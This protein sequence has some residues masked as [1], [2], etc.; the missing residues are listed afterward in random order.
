MKKKNVLVSLG[1][2]VA[3]MSSVLAGCAGSGSAA[4]TTTSATSV[5]S[6]TEGSAQAVQVAPVTE[7]DAKAEITGN[8]VFYTADPEE[9]A[10][11][12]CE[13]FIA[14]Y[15][16]CTYTLYRSGTGNLTTKLSAETE[17]GGTEC[18][19]F[20]FSNLSYIYGLEED[21]MLYHWT[22]DG[23]ENLIDTT[24]GDMAYNYKLEV[25]GIAYNTSL[26][27]QAPTSFWDLS[28]N[29]Y[30]S[31]V[32]FADPSYSGAALTAAV[33]HAYNESVTGFDYYQAMKDNALKFEQS[34]G[35]LQSK[36]S[37]G[38]Y[39]AVVIVDYMARNAKASGSPVDFVYP[40][41]GGIVVYSPF[42]I[43]NTVKEEDLAAV[44]AFSEFLLG[45]TAQA[46][47]NKYNYL[48][49]VTTASLPEGVESFDDIKLMGFD[50]DYYVEN[51][52]AVSTK[53]FEMFG[54]N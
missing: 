40:E 4:E 45:D 9:I 37:T 36:V 48:P 51:C 21:G 35:N 7:A 41:E 44:E 54:A 5:A 46:I 18:N 33:T 17:A 32:A 22:P 10:T 34:N 29:N 11:E 27:N 3:M 19:C 1:L 15:P 2:T 23:A 13:A 49:G 38:E 53:Y 12:V 52:D 25:C 47:Y 16:N 14:E 26:I 8:V 43:L 24:F 39:A 42:C 28:E 30:N 6:T 31:M 20:S 50:L